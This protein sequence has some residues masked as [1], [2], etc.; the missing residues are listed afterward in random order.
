MPEPIVL[1]L[2]RMLP[3]DLP[4]DASAGQGPPTPPAQH[5]T[6]QPERKARQRVPALSGQT[7]VAT[8]RRRLPGGGRLVSFSISAEADGNRTRLGARAPTT[9]LKTEGPTRNPDASAGQ[10]TGLLLLVY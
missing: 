7:A 6:A 3:P 1:R 4:A 9:V 10:L 8:W 5:P 2:D